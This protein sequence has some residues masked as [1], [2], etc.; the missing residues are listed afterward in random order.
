MDI[1]FKEYRECILSDKKLLET[2]IKGK[3][4][5]VKGFEKI[6]HIINFYNKAYEEEYWGSIF[7]DKF[8]ENKEEKIYWLLSDFIKPL[9]VLEKK[10]DEVIKNYNRNYQYFKKR[11]S[12]TLNDLKKS[13]ISD[14]KK[15]E[16]KA[17]NIRMD[18][19]S[20]GIFSHEEADR[21][22]F[23]NTYVN[24]DK[25]EKTTH[26]E[27]LI[28]D[29]YEQ[30]FSYF[31]IK[32]EF[33]SSF[34][35]KIYPK[36]DKKRILWV[37]KLNALNN[38]PLGDLINKENYHIIMNVANH[39]K[40]QTSI[41]NLPGIDFLNDFMTCLFKKLKEN[42]NFEK[43]SNAIEDLYNEIEGTVNPLGLTGLE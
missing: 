35:I 37:D 8:T 3:L 14:E 34:G 33:L 32:L 42:L 4:P 28:N 22:K 7:Y 18:D 31:Y 19:I 17:E 29:I 21:R 13:K 2:L 11:F 12:K 30:F 27:I 41:L 40:H 1:T 16:E 10:L 26:L 6:I 39:Y 23:F 36:N 15:N 9:G 43:F 20:T 25:S 38:L 24:K 5:E